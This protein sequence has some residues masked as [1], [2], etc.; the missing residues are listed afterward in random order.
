MFIKEENISNDGIYTTTSV[1]TE[2]QTEDISQEV[3]DVSLTLLSF[4][5][6]VII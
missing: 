2:V 3:E 4:F 1:V 6:T 5:C